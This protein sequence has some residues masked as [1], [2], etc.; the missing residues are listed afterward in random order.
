[1]TKTIT[2]CERHNYRDVEFYPVSGDTPECPRCIVERDE[3][4]EASR[5]PCCSRMNIDC[6]GHD[7]G[8]GEP[9]TGDDAL[10]AQ[11]RAVVSNHGSVYGG[12][13]IES[14]NYSNCPP[15]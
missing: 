6:C 5:R 11:L 2:I 7:D 14:S 8:Q 10:R 4:Y 12:L 15:F 9:M 3:A 1:M 13:V